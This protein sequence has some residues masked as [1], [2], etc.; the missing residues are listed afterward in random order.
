MDINGN[1]RLD[2]DEPSQIMQ[3]ASYCGR[4]SEISC[5]TATLKVPDVQVG[6]YNVL[7][8]SSSGNIDATPAQYRV[9]DPVLVSS[10]EEGGINKE[11]SITAKYL[12]VGEQGTVYFDSNNNNQLDEG[13]T[14]QNLQVGDG[15]SAEV[16]LKSANV[17]PGKYNIRYK[18]SSRKI[19]MDPVQY[20]VIAASLQNYSNPSG[21][22]TSI[23]IIGRNLPGSDE[24]V[25][26]FD[27]NNNNE[28]DSGEPNK[29]I[30]TDSVGNVATSL[31]TPNVEPGTY[32]I[33]YRSSFGTIEINS[34]THRIMTP[35]INSSSSEGGAGK[36]VAVT[37]AYLAP[38][39]SGT[40]YFDNNNN[41]RLDEDEVKQVVSSD[42]QGEFYAEV[43]IPNIEPGEYSIQYVS[44]ANPVIE[45]VVKFK[46][47]GRTLITSSGS[48]S[49]GNKVFI[50]GKNFFPYEVGTL[51]FDS[52][53]NGSL[54]E[55]ETKVNLTS[56]K[57]GSFYT[58][59]TIPDVAPGDYN[60]RFSSEDKLIKVL[61][62]TYKVVRPLSPNVNPVSNSDKVVTGK[63][64]PNNG[65]TVSLDGKLLGKSVTD[66][67]GN[68]KV[69]IAPQEVGAVLIVKTTD[70]D[71]N[72]SQEV[73]VSI[74][75]DKTAP[76]APKVDAV[77]DQSTTV[78][79]TTEASANVSVK[80]GTEV[81]GSGNADE[82]GKYSVEISKQKAG[83]TIEISAK[84]N[85]GNES[86][87]TV[88]TVQDKTAPASP[89]VDTISDQSITVTGTTE[90]N[91]SVL[92]KV[93]PKTIGSGAANSKGSFSIKIS[94]QKAGTNVSVSAKD[95][96]GNE[97]KPTVVTVQDKTAPA[98]PK[99]NTVSDQST[100]VTGTAEA[101]ASVSVKVG[102]K[103]IGSGKI[104][105]NGK[106]SVKISKQK[107]GTKVAV[108]A[109]DNAGNES[110]PTVVTVQDKTAPASPKVNTVSDQSTTVTG[111]AEANASVS[112]KVGTKVIGSGKVDK[113][114]KYSVKISKQKAGTKVAVSAKDNAGN[115]SKPTVVTVQ[116]KTAPVP[117]KVNNISVR[118]TT[119]TGTTEANASVSV[120][121]GPKTIGSGKANSKGAFSIKISKQKAGTKVTI[122]AKDNA[123]NES[124]STKTVS[125]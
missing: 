71:G 32:N 62:T 61:P 80:V 75:E 86:K 108:S 15:G 44:S 66:N 113:N 52:N 2:S 120:K 34:L 47:I 10:F 93:G 58:G 99:V 5:V 40:V 70:E 12:P 101:N 57:D 20:N 28:L 51:Y 59:L 22:N 38:Y 65:V 9:L 117:P 73:K 35:L 60:I 45:K 17:K 118:S 49:I 41:G 90:A 25:I 56:E 19:Y 11:I 94:K 36:T 97:S 109:K 121:V 119:V 69:Q 103:V 29:S 13:E 111:T 39:T 124:K 43:K 115:E 68:F 3:E 77:S 23:N 92:V 83:T 53:S 72:E 100:T 104:D 31:K 91:A 78:T 89:K 76:D 95:N 96:A 27:S 122:I 102:A 123:G 64:E 55:G 26:Y 98:S 7:Y 21:V 48:G 74:Q 4:W 79:G 63:G 24:G 112:V 107:A 105:K 1:W 54:D 87:S 114:G 8:V 14:S 46:V 18:S 125:K 84:D 82:N 85:A 37:G 42:S 30:K 67:E 6:I 81:I 110:K 16:K 106:Y 50:T 88:V 116:D 33:R